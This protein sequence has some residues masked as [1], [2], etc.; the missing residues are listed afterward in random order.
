VWFWGGWHKAPSS[1]VFSVPK[2]LAGGFTSWCRTGRKW[3][4]G[5]KKGAVMQGAMSIRTEGVLFFRTL[6]FCMEDKGRI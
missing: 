1:C 2:V 4:R 3:L 6:S 5:K